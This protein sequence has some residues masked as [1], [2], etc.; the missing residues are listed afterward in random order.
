[1]ELHQL[2]YL[3]AV[4]EEGGFTRAAARLRIAQPGVSAQIRKLERE[5]GQPL[6]DRSARAVRPTAAGQAV[7][8][9]ARAALAA[10]DGAR[11]AVDE[12]TG[13]TRGRVAIGTVTSHAVD[14][15]GILAD[16]NA[17]HPLVEITMVEDASER[18]VAAV[19]EGRLDAAI[20]ALGATD[21]AGLGVDVVSD[22]AID[23][24]VWPGHELADR[25]TIPLTALRDRALI[26][27]PRGGAIR[28]ILEEA[29]A[30]AGF[31]PRVAFEAGSP[32]VLEQLAARRLGVAILPSSIARHRAHLHALRIVRPSL[33]GRLGLA[34]R[35]S[36]PTS[37]AAAAWLAHARGRL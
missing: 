27:L 11:Q 37:P 18:L 20:V 25:D 34:W 4:I 14:L 2:E 8:P 12:L 13:L 29:C 9:Y 21:P 36:G 26:C 23:A 3:V 6:L 7:L 28:A 24:A 35:Q 33:R 15:A 30:A 22:E 19:L 17:R 32:A 16:F 5:L 1:M 10:V 31:T